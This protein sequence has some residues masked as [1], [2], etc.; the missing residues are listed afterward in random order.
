MLLKFAYCL[1]S[2]C[3]AFCVSCNAA[4]FPSQAVRSYPSN[5]FCHMH[6]ETI[7]QQRPATTQIFFSKKLFQETKWRPHSS[8]EVHINI[9]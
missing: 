1:C 6:A 3:C 7:P 4:V 2:C 5:T 9:F 8:S